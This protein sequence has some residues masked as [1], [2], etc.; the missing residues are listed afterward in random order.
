MAFDMSTAKPTQK[1]GFD[2]ASAKPLQAKAI[3]TDVPSPE[4][5]A[6][7]A[8]GYANRP[9]ETPVSMMDRVKALPEV[10]ATMATGATTGL[11]GNIGGTLQQ[12]GREIMGGQF[13]TPEAANRIEQRAADVGAS[14]TYSPKSPAAQEMLGAIGDVAAPFAGAAGLTAQMNIAGNAARAGMPALRLSLIHISEP[15]R[16]CGTS[17]MPSSA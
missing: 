8:Q 5:D 12:A 13:G 11:L 17:R 2:I 3:N 6:F 14:A 7:V 16:P 15:T 1:K 4:Q 9:A 10:S